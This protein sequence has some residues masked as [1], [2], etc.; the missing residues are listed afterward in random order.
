LSLH[1]RQEISKTN[2]KAGYPVPGTNSIG[3]HKLTFYTT[4]QLPSAVSSQL[5]YRAANLL[6][7]SKLIQA[8]AV[9]LK[10]RHILLPRQLSREFVSAVVGSG[11]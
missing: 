5:Y 9:I 10:T 2:K 4:L 3:F 7:T 6:T 1:N 11:V 8:D